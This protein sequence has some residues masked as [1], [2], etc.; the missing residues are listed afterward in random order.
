MH[1]NYTVFLKITGFLTMLCG[2]GMVP[3][4]VIGLYF[5]EWQ[6]AS[7]LFISSICLIVIGS[8][9]HAFTRLNQV[10]L[11]YH[12]GWLIACVSWVY[13]SLLGMIPIY[14]CGMDYTLI[15]SFFE[16]VAGFTTTGCSVFDI[17]IML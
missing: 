12:E 17:N 8:V 16:S 2:C 9:I 10:R 3:C 7:A 4:C 15:G 13:C 11:R 5:E 1:I 14:F 6:A